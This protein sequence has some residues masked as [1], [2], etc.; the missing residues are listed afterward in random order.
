MPPARRTVAHSARFGAQ[1]FGDREAH[2]RRVLFRAQEILVGDV[3]Q[4]VAVERD[5]ALIAIFMSGP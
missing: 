1:F 4:R 3:L 2:A 5:E